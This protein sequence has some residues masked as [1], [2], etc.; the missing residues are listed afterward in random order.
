MCDGPT[1]TV[2]PFAILG[3]GTCMTATY[4]GDA[5]GGQTSNPLVRAALAVERT[6]SL[7]ALVARIT[8]LAESL[9]GSGARR[10]ALQ[11]RWLGHAVHPLFVMVPMGM[12]TGVSILDLL[13]DDASRDVAKRLTGWGLVFAAPSAATGWAE[14]VDTNQRDRRTATVHALSNITAVVCYAASWRAR[15]NGRHGLGAV[16]AGTGYSA[17]SVG[18]FLGGHL[19]EGRKVGSHHPAIAAD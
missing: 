16:L 14:W 17:A 7:D 18:G 6:E 15:R 13:G 2:G 4:P 19:T 8:P 5:T 3:T 9:V 1:E 11:G 10:E 12:W